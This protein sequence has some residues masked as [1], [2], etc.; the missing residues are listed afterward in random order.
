MP[1]GEISTFDTLQHS[2]I[3]ALLH[4][5]EASRSFRR[6]INTLSPPPDI[7]LARCNALKPCSLLP[8]HAIR[9]ILT[10]AVRIVRPGG[11]VFFTDN[12]PRS[13]VIQSLPPAIFTLM[14]S[15]EVRAFRALRAHR[16]D[17][18]CD[19]H[20]LKVGRMRTVSWQWGARA[21][22][23]TRCF[24]RNAAVVGPVLHDRHQGDHERA[25]PRRR[26]VSPDGPP[27]PHRFGA[28]AQRLRKRGILSWLHTFYNPAR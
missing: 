19:R 27:T 20:T 3:S 24:G 13:P 28:Q 14:K 10:E 21:R 12:D 23:T 1:R 26:G 9:D 18:A 6:S 4:Y 11:V 5:T 22:L 16:P 25:R 17:R 8:Q 2:L 7:R 15:T